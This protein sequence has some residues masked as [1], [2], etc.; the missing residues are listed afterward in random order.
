MRDNA[1]AEFESVTPTDFSMYDLGDTAHVGWYYI[2]VANKA[3]IWMDP[4]L[5]ENVHI[6]MISYV[7]PFMWMAFPSVFSV[8][9]FHEACQ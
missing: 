3:P 9:I 5:N 2:P 7:V 4:Y 1:E 8:W 6:Y